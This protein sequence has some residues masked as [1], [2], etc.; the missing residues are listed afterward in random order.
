TS[1]GGTSATGPADQFS[2]APSVT[3]LEPSSGP[4]AGGTSVTISGTNFNE[5]TAVR[6]GPSNATNYT[7]NSTGSITATSP[8]GVGTVDVTVTTAGGT[9]AT[10]AADQFSFGPTIAKVEPTRGATE[11]G[12][13]VTI[14]GANLAGATGVKFGSTNATTFTVNSPTSMN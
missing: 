1:G 9:S 13:L 6:F 12:T 4:K 14:T 3:S 11:G 5:V 7:V 10:S 2:Y 8:A